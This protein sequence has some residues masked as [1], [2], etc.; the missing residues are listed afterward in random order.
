M[1]STRAAVLGEQ[2]PLV[3][4][5]P[6]RVD[7]SDA[8]D[9]IAL[10]ADYGL[11]PDPWQETVLRDWLARRRDGKWAAS[12]CGLAVP[13]Q[14]GKNAAIEV[15]ELFGMVVLGEKWLH[16]AHEVKTARKAFLRL[17]SFFENGRKYP[18]LV[19]LVAE[20]R[21]TNGQEAI[22]LHNGGS[23]EFVARSKGSGRG[24]TVDGIVLDEAQEL[25]DEAL[26]ALLPTTS[27]GPLRNAQHIYTG[28]P[29]G[30]KVNGEVFKRLRA[31]GHDGKDKRLSWIEWG[32]ASSIA[33]VDLDDRAAWARANPGLGY[34]LGIPEIEGERT[35]FSDEGFARERGGMWDEG[36]SLREV[37]PAAW[38][39][40][41]DP[42]VDVRNVRGPI[43]ALDVAPHHASASIVA[44]GVVDVPLLE[45]VEHRPGASWLPAR[46][47]ELCERYG[48]VVA[49]NSGGPI[50]SLIP[51]LE[52][53]GV[54]FV[55]VRGAD[56]TKA[57]GLFAAAVN[58]RSLR[59]RNEPEFAA[60]IL[61]LKTRRNGD[62][63]S[64]SRADS[65][66]DITPIVAASVA[67]WV[68]AQERAPLTQDELLQT[69]Y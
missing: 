18:E 37:S 29:P 8:D 67:V 33:E 2:R 60:A 58:G 30:P 3:H 47:A 21:K 7:E 23:V 19:E 40:L 41:A 4:L 56:Y 36:G 50:G 35:Q 9:A 51:A 24:F 12:K 53:L 49:L 46:A 39:A 22:V 42:S 15:R 69:F 66:V 54:E 64:W 16:T 44:A 38:A 11:K 52:D 48:G 5:I 61:G 10:G 25:V 20:V 17:A 34:R 55:D 43:L 59:H 57:C 14:N 28:T 45:L 63:F 1:S 13:R 62:G 27:A 65:S 32:M 68:A 26:E 31:A 6:A